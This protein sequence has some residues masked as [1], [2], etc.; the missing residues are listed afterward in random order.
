MTNGLPMS[1]TKRMPRKTSLRPS[2]T[3]R[4]GASRAA[5][6]PGRVMA[7]TAPYL[8]IF[9]H[10]KCCAPILSSP[11]HIADQLVT[12]LTGLGFDARRALPIPNDSASSGPP[13]R[14]HFIGFEWH[15]GGENL[16]R[17]RGGSTRPRGAYATSADF[18]VLLER[19]DGS[20]Q[21]LLGE[22]K[23]TETYDATPKQFS[24]R[25]TNRAT[26]YEH[27]LRSKWNPIHWRENDLEIG[28]LFFDPFDQLM[29]LQLLAAA[30]EHHWTDTCDSARLLW[31]LPSANRALRDSVTSPALLR[32][33]ERASIPAN[34]SSIWTY[35][36]GSERFCSVAAESVLEH[37]RTTLADL[38][39]EWAE[40]MSARYDGLQ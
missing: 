35:L 7:M 25:G 6:S 15:D 3:M 17:E 5:T 2:V 13:D 31:V 23:Y 33:A 11:S 22:W 19:T 14:V 16:L 27:A 39:P 40:W 20:R 38:E 36:V 1:Y 8:A 9:A 29:R 28:D 26:I 4:R 10:R 18:V 32:L 24:E 34:V 30:I 12:L 37:A 21:F